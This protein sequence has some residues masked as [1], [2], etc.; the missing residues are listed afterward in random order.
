MSALAEI[1]GLVLLAQSSGGSSGGSSSGGGSGGSSGG[2]MSGGGEMSS[3]D[4]PLVTPELGLMVWTLIAFGV[5]MYVLYKV[6]FPRISSA[7]EERATR[8]EKNIDESERQREEAESLLAEYRGRLKEAREQSE[9]IVA[10]AKKAG[11]SSKQDSIDEGKAKR[12]ELVEQARKEIESEK[13]RSIEEIRKQVADLTVLATE[14]VARKSLTQED[15]ERLVQDALDE[16]DFSALAG[17]G[18]GAS[19]SGNGSDS[20][21]A[22]GGSEAS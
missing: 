21:S 6:A 15:Q 7:L 18:A 3:G 5:S 12:D 8:I 17:S 9:D 16:V 14:R 19:S 10:R 11:E 1:P 2:E 4:S 20:S 13:K 22:D